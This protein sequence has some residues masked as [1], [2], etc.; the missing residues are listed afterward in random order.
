MQEFI[1]AALITAK[2]WKQSTCPLSKDWIHDV[3]YIHTREYNL[4]VHMNKLL[5]HSTTGKKSKNMLSEKAK[6]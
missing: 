1:T 6:Q 5:I 2:K 3:W 4:A